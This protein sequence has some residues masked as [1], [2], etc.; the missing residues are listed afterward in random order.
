[1]ANFCI[2]NFVRDPSPGDRLM[3]IYNCAGTLV[4][5]IDPYTSTA[6]Q[7]SRYAYIMR[8]GKINYDNVLDF[9]SD[10]EAEQ[11]IARFDD[12]KNFL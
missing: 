2:G 6:F 12:V 9:A 11:A 7:K 10:S 5:A 1:M 3:Y 4:M 8:D